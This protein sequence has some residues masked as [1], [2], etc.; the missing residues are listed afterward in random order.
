[1]KPALSKEQQAAK[2]AQEMGGYRGV[3]RGMVGATFG[4]GVPAYSQYSTGSTV[5]YASDPTG[6]APGYSIGYPPSYSGP[7]ASPYG[8][9]VPSYEV[10]GPPAYATVRYPGEFFWNKS[11]IWRYHVGISWNL[12]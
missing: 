5:V 3:G 7:V 11:F 10:Q 12:W 6:G 4:Y 1:M 2:K 9:A 8:A